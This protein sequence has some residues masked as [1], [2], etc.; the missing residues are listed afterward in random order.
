VVVPGFNGQPTD[1]TVTG[2]EVDGVSF[3]GIVSPGAL[4]LAVGPDSPFALS[5]E[6]PS[7]AGSSYAPGQKV[8]L[9]ILTST[10]DNYSRSVTL[11]S[12]YSIPGYSMTLSAYVKEGT[13]FVIVR[14]Y[15][16]W[17]VFVEQVVFNDTPLA[18]GAC[19]F[20]GG[21]IEYCV[22]T[23]MTGTLSFPVSGG[24]SGETYAVTLVTSE[25]GNYTTYVTW[26]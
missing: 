20:F 8:L 5:F 21:F 22:Y 23:F 9:K 25:A 13:V 15:S 4:P 3:S 18:P 6:I 11:P 14:N 7:G 12:N 1:A 24:R 2:I 19:E 16:M 17:S 10:G 26:P